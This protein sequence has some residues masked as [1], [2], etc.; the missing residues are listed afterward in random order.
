MRFEPVPFLVLAIA[1]SSPALEAEDVGLEELLSGI[2]TNRA[3]QEYR[4]RERERGLDPILSPLLESDKD[5][6]AILKALQESLKV[7]APT[8]T[9]LLRAHL[10]EKRLERL[11]SIDEDLNAG[12]VAK[13]ESLYREAFRGAPDCPAAV[14]EVAGFY[15]KH[16]RDFFRDHPRSLLELIEAAPSPG[17]SAFLACDADEAEPVLLAL[18]L[19]KL[20]GNAAVLEAVASRSEDVILLA[21]A[22]RGEA[23]RRPLPHRRRPPPASPGTACGGCSRAA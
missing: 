14:E 17:R 22:L 7:P 18:A 4:G 23:L 16:A 11:P 2:R 5:F 19:E 21:A 20:P 8:A 3:N 15:R 13:I 9:T 1:A 12:E 6:P 10:L